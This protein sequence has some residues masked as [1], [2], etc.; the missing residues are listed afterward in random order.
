VVNFIINSTTMSAGSC[1]DSLR[2]TESVKPETPDFTT[3]DRQFVDVYDTNG[4]NYTSG[5]VTFDL[6]ALVNS[7]RYL[8]LKSTYLTI[9][10]TL[11]LTVGG[12]T[13]PS[14]AVNAFAASLKNGNHQ[15]INGLTV[16]LANQSVVNLQQFSNIPMTYNILSVW[17]ETDEQL[18]GPSI[19]F[20]KDGGQ[21]MTWTAANGEFNNNVSV[22]T[23][24]TPLNPYPVNEGRA[25]RLSRGWAVPVAGT[26]V[27]P[28]GSMAATALNKINLTDTQRS[29][30]DV[31]VSNTQ[32]RFEIMANIY[33]KHLHDLFDK[34]PIHRGALWQM[35]FHTHLP[36]TYACTMAA[37][38]QNASPSINQTPYGFNPFMITTPIAAD[39][40]GFQTVAT[41]TSITFASSISNSMQSTC[42]LHCAMMDLENSV[43]AAYI[44]NPRRRVVYK[45]FIRNSP[46]GLQNVPAG[47]SMRA[48]LTAGIAKPRGLLIFPHLAS[49]SNGTNG[50]S[51]LASPWTSCGGTTAF[52]AQMTNFNVQVNGANIYE[53]NIRYRYDHFLREQFGVLSPSGNGVDGMRVGLLD[54]QDFNGCH[55]WVWVNLERHPKAND[56]V[57][58]AIDI[59]ITNGTQLT[60]SYMCFIFFEREFEIDS[61]TGKL[62]I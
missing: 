22:A 13:M 6:Q 29:F 27:V 28:S 32:I 49:G 14:T 15:L 54:E 35:T 51:A 2:I 18:L 4:L 53:K 61:F 25:K 60:M 3:K 8:D 9:P 38:A 55:A 24:A 16:N 41:P 34:M 62:V 37:F 21:S 39:T 1:Y 52:G 58:A 40:T 31:Q 46:S 5:Q 44:A 17:N 57:P 36:T 19:G 23:A 50:V 43:S 10:L 45:D 30:V 26:A 7:H 48:N 20:A 42:V 33:L 12:T 59:E 47:A 56:N 11:T